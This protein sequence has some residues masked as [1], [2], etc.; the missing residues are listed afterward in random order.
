MIGSFPW[1][2]SLKSARHGRCPNS[3]CASLLQHPGALRKC[4]SGRHD[5]IHY[6][7]GAAPHMPRGPNA[8]C[9]AHVGDTLFAAESYLRNGCPLTNQYSGRDFNRLP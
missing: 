6:D 9:I 4:G 2:R 1:S 7:H 3:F 5:V 8:K